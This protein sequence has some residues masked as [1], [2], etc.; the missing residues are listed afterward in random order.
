[1]MPAAPLNPTPQVGQRVRVDLSGMQVPDG[2]LGP[3]AVATGT[4]THIDPTSG[5]LTIRLDTSV[6][7]YNLVTADPSRILAIS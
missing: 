1:M 6:G 5:R 7:G 3:A 4:V 2:V